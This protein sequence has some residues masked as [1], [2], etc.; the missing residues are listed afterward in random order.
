MTSKEVMLI[1]ER[2]YSLQILVLPYCNN[3]RNCLN[4]FCSLSDI[5]LPTGLAMFV[6]HYDTP[7]PQPPTYKHDIK[8]NTSHFLKMKVISF[9]KCANIYS[10]TMFYLCFQFLCLIA[11]GTSKKGLKHSTIMKGGIKTVVSKN[12][13][14]LDIIILHDGKK[15]KNSLKLKYRGIEE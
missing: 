13:I 11:G 8:Q 5:M 2:K 4:Y 14:Q 1:F 3:Q 6:S 10:C 15:F 7:P 12:N 9:Y